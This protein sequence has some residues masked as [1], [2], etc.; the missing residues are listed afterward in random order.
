[1]NGEWT[2]IS[3]LQEQWSCSFAVISAFEE[4]RVRMEQVQEQVYWNQKADIG[5]GLQVNRR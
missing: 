2:H 5:W 3:R 4:V 1:M